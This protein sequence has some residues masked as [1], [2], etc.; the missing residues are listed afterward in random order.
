MNDL[1]TIFK[2]TLSPLDKLLTLEH[3][4]RKQPQIDLRVRHHFSHGIYAREL[5]IPAGVMLTGEIHKYPQLN[6][7]TQGRMSVL[8]GEE[9]KEISAPFTVSSEA[10]TKR[11]AIAHDDSI[12]MT[13]H[14]THLKNIEEIEEYFI[15][16][17]QE[18]YLEFCGQLK[19]GLKS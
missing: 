5:F 4:M 12:W 2:D 9:V 8:V 11:I 16:K 14:G 15:A 19:L 10:G 1:T 7:L 17:S 3:E 18:E 6:I 13:I